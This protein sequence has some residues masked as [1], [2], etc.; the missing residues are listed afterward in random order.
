MLKEESEKWDEK[1]KGM[2]EK[3]RGFEDLKEK[4]NE[5]EKRRDELL[6]DLEKMELQ[7][8]KFW[9]NLFEKWKFAPAMLGKFCVN[10][11]HTILGI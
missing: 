10:N 11:N 6:L 3:L 7:A 1:L 4:K 9:T 2:Q 5:M 8:E